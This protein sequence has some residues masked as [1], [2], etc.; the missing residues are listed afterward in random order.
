LNHP[1]EKIS[2]GR[3]TPQILSSVLSIAGVLLAGTAGIAAAQKP[4]ASAKVKH[5][6]TV[7]KANCIGC[8]NKEPGDTTP[9]GPPNL[10]GVL[11]KNPVL[12]PQQATETIKQGK[13]VMPPF[14]GKL[15]DSDINA[16]VAYLKTL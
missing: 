9:F 4:A 6:E 12:T 3:N 7:F 2:I 10:H 16:V 13:G 14:A 8:H 11:G 5:G 15:N 1:L